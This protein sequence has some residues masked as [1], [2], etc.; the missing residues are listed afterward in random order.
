MRD[1]N[2]ARAKQMA[3]RM[4]RDLD[5]ADPPTLAEGETLN[6]RLPPDP[7]ADYFHARLGRQVS[8]HAPARVV[9]V[10][11][12]DQSP[13]DLPPGIDIKTARRTIEATR[14][15]PN[16]WRCFGS[17]RNHP[18]PIDDP[19]RMSKIGGSNIERPTS[20]IEYRISNVDSSTARL[21][22]NS[23]LNRVSLTYDY[24]VRLN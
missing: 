22:S 3:R 10:P 1:T 19:E 16:Q 18:G 14:G 21:R 12:G 4:E 7:F 17:D 9:A 6:F 11:V 5:L 13:L 23:S 8:S 24:F 15:D 2:L 20:N